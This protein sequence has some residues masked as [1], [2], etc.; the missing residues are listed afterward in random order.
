M[1]NA[2][3]SNGFSDIEVPVCSGGT[4]D[5]TT[6]SMSFNGED[7]GAKGT[8]EAT[9]N[10]GAITAW[11]KVN[12]ASRDETFRLR[13]RVTGYKALP[14]AITIDGVTVQPSI[15][16]EAGDA[17]VSAWT[18][19][20]NG[21]AFAIAGSGADPT[22]DEQSPGIDCKRVDFNGGKYFLAA[23]SSVGAIG[24]NDFVM[25][26]VFQYDP[27]VGVYIVDKIDPATGLADSV[28]LYASSGLLRLYIDSAG[29]ATVDQVLASSLI[30]GAYYHVIIFFDRSG[31]LVGYVNGTAGTAASISAFAADNLAVN[32]KWAVGANGTNGGNPYISGVS[33]FALWTRA[34]WL[35]SHLQ[36]GVAA[37][38]FAQ[39]CGTYAETAQLVNPGF[40]D[41]DMEAADAAA[42]TAGS[43]ATLSKETGTR[44]GG[45]GAKVLRIAGDGSTS[46]PRALQTK[47]GGITRITGWARSNGTAVPTV[48][49]T[50]VTLWTG[51]NSTSWQSFDISV[52][53][54]LYSSTRL[55]LGTT[56]AT[57]HVEFDDVTIEVDGAIPTTATRSVA[58]RLEKW[59]TANTEAYLIPVGANWIRTD[60]IKCADGTFKIGA[61]IE[62]GQTNQLLYSEDF[63]NGAWTKTRVTLGTPVV[64]LGS[65]NF[66][67]IIA[68]ADNDTHLV[69][70]G[71]TTAASESHSFSIYAKAGAVNS[72]KIELNEDAT[73]YAYYNLST[74]LV[75]DVGAGFTLTQPAHIYDKG[76]SYYRCEFRPTTAGITGTIN[77]YTS[78][79]STV[80]SETFAGNGTATS[81]WLSGAQFERYAS[82][83]QQSGSL[84]SYV[85]TTSATATR[86]K[87]TLTFH[88][89]ENCESKATKNIST[90]IDYVC[91]VFVAGYTGYRAFGSLTAKSANDRIEILR[92]TAAAKALAYVAVGGSAQA[93]FQSASNVLFDRNS[94]TI[95]LCAAKN[96]INIVLARALDASDASANLPELQEIV[97]GASTAYTSQL[98]G[99]ITDFLLSKYSATYPRGVLALDKDA[100]TQSAFVGYDM[101]DEDALTYELR[102]GAGTTRLPTMNGGTLNAGD[103]HL[104]SLEWSGGTGISLKID[105]VTVDTAVADATIAGLT[106]LF[107]AWAG[108]KGYVYEPAG[109]DPDY[110][111]TF[112]AVSI[113]DVQYHSAAPPAAWYTEMVARGV[114]A[115]NEHLIHQISQVAHQAETHYDFISGI[116]G[117]LTDEGVISAFVPP[118]EIGLAL[119]APLVNKTIID[120]GSDF[121][122]MQETSHSFDAWIRVDGGG[123]Q[124]V[125]ANGDD[126]GTDFQGL[127]YE[128]ATNALVYKC[129]IGAT[130]RLVRAE[131]ETERLYHVAVTRDYDSGAGA[132]TLTIYLDA[133]PVD[134]QIYTGAPV[135]TNDDFAMLSTSESGGAFTRPLIGA[136]V[137]NRFYDDALTQAEVEA[138]YAADSA[139]ILNGP[140]ATQTITP[141]TL[142][143][144]ISGAVRPDGSSGYP[145]VLVQ[146]QAGGAWRAIASAQNASSYSEFSKQVPVNDFRLYTKDFGAYAESTAYFDELDG[147]EDPGEFSIG[148]VE[149]EAS[150]RK[151]LENIVLQRKP[152][153]AWAVMVVKYT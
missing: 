118:T 18:D 23:S 111:I 119:G 86:I 115:K 121:P 85:K 74:G 90:K 2:T 140:Y 34:S 19:T 9:G 22:I 10:A 100:H 105:G 97:I 101:L 69:A 72:I 67:A 64:A 120:F 151:A 79:G 80:G 50:A 65:L 44:T 152:L 113:A 32:G 88:G 109:D 62:N 1:S 117:T 13:P 108:L 135:V 131:I 57:G 129:I 123:D 27:G 30:T 21:N 66:D 59:N 83:T 47:A 126:N 76:G 56:S 40:L 130:V 5:A 136:T 124:C 43:G 91:P 87:D 63:S 29:G 77:V 8:I 139:V 46:S 53:S 75:G 106:D 141:A 134:I 127:Q 132:T 128:D 137:G 12:D 122:F 11:T 102:A 16:L 54:Y 114:P 68:S 104:I 149:I 92:D 37:K 51:S 143:A 125:W 33:Y 39:C 116:A 133:V 93:N 6:L 148:L 55:D 48:G 3:L 26:V 49:L 4:N 94:Q 73:Q 14:A 45:S 150:R 78:N 58:A 145:I 95:E 42:W 70:Q 60:K 96:N 28:L 31:S 110:P 61:R 144:T 52:S 17:T 99:I 107:L 24:T 112:G 25:E 38:R 89:Y 103:W 20:V 15:R 41:L 98:D 138:I 153:H 82:A 7:Q 147:G 35:V 142:P 146:E 84:T 71:V 36:P 81:C